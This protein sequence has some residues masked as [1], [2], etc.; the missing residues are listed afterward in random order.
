MKDL[1]FEIVPFRFQRPGA[2]GSKKKPKVNGYGQ[3]K[4]GLIRDFI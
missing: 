4:D 3:I 2:S 1:S